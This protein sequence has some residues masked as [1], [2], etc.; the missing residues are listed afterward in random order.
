MPGFVQ[1]RL[2][3]HHNLPVEKTSFIDHQLRRPNVAFDDRFSFEH[4]LLGRDDG[5][6]Y[7]AADCDILRRDISVNF[8]RDPDG[9]AFACRDLTGDLPVNSEVSLTPDFPFDDSSRSNQVEFF[10]R[11]SFQSRSSF[12]S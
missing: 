4:D 9:K 10:Y 2:L 3:G 7:L 11:I 12:R 6:P 8:A 1:L 5:S